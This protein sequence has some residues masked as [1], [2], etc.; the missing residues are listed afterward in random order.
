MCQKELLIK[1]W[2]RER[3]IKVVRFPNPPTHPFKSVWFAY[4]TVV[5]CTNYPPKYPPTHPF[6]S[7]WHPGMGKAIK[8]THM[9]TYLKYK[10]EYIFAYL[11]Y[12]YFHS[13][14]Y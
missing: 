5:L 14:K 8:G 1:A 2:D 11:K 13:I 10:I 9:F 7:V 4:I 12:K 3:G 6:K